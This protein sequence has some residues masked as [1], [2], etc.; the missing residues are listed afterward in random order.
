MNRLKILFITNWYPTKVEPAKAI[1][2]RE[3]AKAVRLYD[4]VCVLHCVGTDPSLKKLWRTEQESNEALREGIPTHRVWYRPLP[5]A[6]LLYLVYCWSMFRTFQQIV[7]EGFRP[8][9]IHVHVYDA[10]GPAI[11]IGKLNHIPVVV[12]EQFSSFPRA[13]LG[14][15]DRLKAWFAFRWADLVLPVSQALQKAIENY[16]LRARF[17]VIPNV[18]DPALFYPAS[19]IRADTPFK[20][21]LYVGQLLP[22]KGIPNLFQA[23]SRLRQ[24]REDW[25]LDIVGDGPARVEYETL[26]ADLKLSDKVTFQGLKTKR[27]VAEFMRGADL[28]VLPSLYETF[29]APAIE[30]LTT[31]TP[32]LA[33]R[34]GG[35][36]DFV[37]KE[38]G[39]LV[40]P[41]DADALRAGLDYM[42]DRLHL[43]P[44][45]EISEYA[46]KLFSPETVGAKLD[47]V[48]RMV[49]VR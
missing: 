10:G 11:L 37:T 8:D 18:A 38:V 34:C 3:H 44:Y 17:Q 48:Y 30:A 2:A 22:V 46:A 42:L 24:S 9:V 23:L 45:R 43:Y 41:G 5:I 4:D 13:L 26:A 29:S 39:L 19:G 25:H 20:R 32:V 47:A 40:A 16:G 31:G 36:D 7:K 15:L 27:D 21:L 6:N 49:T 12:T 33:T 14:R 28:F 1:W 35:P